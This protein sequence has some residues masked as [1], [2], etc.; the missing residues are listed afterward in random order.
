MNGGMA[1]EQ[2]HSV[3]LTLI[4]EELKCDVE[5]IVDFELQLCDTQPSGYKGA[6]DEFISSGRLDNL[7]HVFM[8]TRAMCDTTADAESL[9]DE[10]SV[11]AFAF[12]DHEEIGS[13]SAQGAGGPIVMDTFRRIASSLGKGLE[14]I[15]ERTLQSSFLISADMAHGVHP[16]YG[17]KHQREHQSMLQQGIVIKHNCNQRYAT[18]VLSAVLFRQFA[19]RAKCPL[20]EFVVR[21]DCACGSTIGPIV[22]GQTG[23]RTVDVGAPQWAM[24]SC[25]ETMG[26]KDVV[27]GVKTL[28]AAYKNFT[29]LST[30]LFVDTPKPQPKI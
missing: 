20:Q 23:L 16:N 28:S 13:K 15:T 11:R 29:E 10:E 6:F 5:D 3:L 1:A 2:H 14:G 24:H 26:V 25:R 27:H 8:C 4:A 12:F 9:A 19:A 7:G 21:N 22:A 30:K 18:N 17:S